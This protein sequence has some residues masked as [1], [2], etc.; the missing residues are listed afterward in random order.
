MDNGE[1]AEG[2]EYGS[3]NVFG[4]QIAKAGN[5]DAYSGKNRGTEKLVEGHWGL[6]FT[7]YGLLFTENELSPSS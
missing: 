3:D 1:E 4:S 2:K 6:W 7:V 5:A